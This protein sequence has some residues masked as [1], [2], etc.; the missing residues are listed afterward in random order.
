MLYRVMV[1]DDEPIM[2]K[3]LM[4][5]T[6]WEETGCEVVYTAAN[7][8]EVLDHLEAALPDILIT[9]IRMPGKDGIELAKYIWEEKLPIKVIILTAYADFSYAQSAVKY[10]VIDYVTKTGAFDGLISAIEKAKME[11][12]RAQQI[13][14]PSDRNAE[15]KNLLKSIFDGSLYGREDLK[16]DMERLRINLGAFTVILLQYRMGKEREKRGMKEIYKSLENFF[17]MVFGE[18]MLS[19]VL[20]E[21]DMFAIVIVNQEEIFKDQLLSQCR[22]IVDMMDNFMQLF[23]YIGVGNCHCKTED[24]KKAYNEAERAIGYGFITK[25][26]KIHF[27]DEA[28]GMEE[29][30]P[31]AAEVLCDKVC[32]EIGKGNGKRA[33]SLFVELLEMQKEGQCSEYMIKN[34][35]ILIQ[36]KCRKLASEHERT[37]YEVAGMNESISKAV[38]RCRY[39]DEYEELMKKIICQTAESIHFVMNKKESIVAECIKFIEG[40][41]EE[42]ILVNDIARALGVSVSYLSRIFKAQ[43]GQTIIFT[44]NQ[45]RLEKAKVYL[46]DTDMKVYQIAEKLGFENTT[47]FSHFFKKYEGVSPKEYKEEE[48]DGMD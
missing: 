31:K 19:A 44:L 6:N 33:W 34:T 35:G 2:R 10:G 29:K 24:L 27:F 46:R 26:S 11:I 40:H 47:Y 16:E 20:V 18:Y 36:S 32:I 38:F 4:T 37:I 48:T 42:N 45:K 43:T 12:E 15:V 17:K 3:A 9:D 7:G 23:T 13:A 22:Q 39:V 14:L 30:Y 41:F 1:A 25:E 21:R 8:Q 5:L 28:D